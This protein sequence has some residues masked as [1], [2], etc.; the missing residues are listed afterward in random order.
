MHEVIWCFWKLQA[1]P[2]IINI[3]IPCFLRG[4]QGDPLR[5][6]GPF[7]LSQQTHRDRLSREIVT[8]SKLLHKHHTESRFGPRSP[9][10]TIHYPH[11]FSRNE[12]HNYSS[13]SHLWTQDW[14]WFAQ[15]INWNNNWAE[16]LELCIPWF[17]SN[18]LC[19]GTCQLSNQFCFPVP[20]RL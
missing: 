13:L 7:S 4:A 20:T 12:D 1:G 14:K 6:V 16:R 19:T 2:I 5:Q 3:C 18:T 15:G 10:S 17:T 11:C 9:W 8:G